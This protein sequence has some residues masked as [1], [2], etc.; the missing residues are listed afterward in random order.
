MGFMKY[1]L[2]SYWDDVFSDDPSHGWFK[3]FPHKVRVDPC[4]PMLTATCWCPHISYQYEYQFKSIKIINQYKPTWITCSSKGIKWGIIFGVFFWM[5]PPMS[6][7]QHLFR[8]DFLHPKHQLRCRTWTTM[9]T[10]G[11]GVQ[12]FQG[13]SSDLGMFFSSR[14]DTLNTHEIHTTIHTTILCILCILSILSSPIHYDAEIP[15]C[16]WCLDRL[17]RR[18][19]GRSKGPM[20]IGMGDS[21]CWLADAVPLFLWLTTCHNYGYLTI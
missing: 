13:D 6:P 18:P 3:E 15:L 19:R 12:G 20:I 14:N 17:H 10:W 16:G 8:L 5:S 9:T 7:V 21:G 1:L 11:Q 2:D 4:W